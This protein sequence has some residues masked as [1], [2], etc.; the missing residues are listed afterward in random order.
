MMTDITPSMRS[1]D[2][3]QREDFLYTQLLK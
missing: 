2:P 1:V 3:A